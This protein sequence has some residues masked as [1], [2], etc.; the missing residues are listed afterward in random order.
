MILTCCNFRLPDEACPQGNG[1]FLQLTFATLMLTTP[2]MVSFAADFGPSAIL[3]PGPKYAASGKS[4]YLAV[5]ANSFLDKSDPLIRKHPEIYQPHRQCLFDY[6]ITKDVMCL[7]H[8][9]EMLRR[10]EF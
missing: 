5:Y 2:S 6:N 10:I 4:R 8:E 7:F 1:I 9:A 3:A